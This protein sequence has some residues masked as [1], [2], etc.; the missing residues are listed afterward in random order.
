MKNFHITIDVEPDLH[1][2]E[3]SSLQEIHLFLDLLKK[4]NIKSTFFVTCDCIKKNPKIFQE[5]KKQ[6]HELA[7]HGFEHRRFDNLAFDEKKSD[8]ENSIKCF[9]KYLKLKPVGFRAPQHSIDSDTLDL[10]KQNDFR[11]D[12]SIIP[13]NIYHL[14]VFWKI[15]IN[16]FHNFESMKPHKKNNLLEIPISSFLL[17]FSSISLRI[18]PKLLLKVFFY[19]LSLYKNPVFFMHSWDL[20]EIPE[21]KIYRLCPKSEYLKRF[22]LLLDYFSKNAESETLENH[23]Q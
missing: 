11:Y 15:K 9:K 14:I 17:P 23:S 5:I 4:Y 2:K 12:S 22:E 18:L 7:L 21:S 10:L 1:T 3:Y 19:F 13:W 16:F 20:I 8:I 6:G